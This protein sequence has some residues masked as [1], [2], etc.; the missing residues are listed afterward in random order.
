MEECFEK[1]ECHGVYDCCHP[2][3]LTIKISKRVNL[4][5]VLFVRSWSVLVSFRGSL[6]Q[7]GNDDAS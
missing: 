1:I 4:H 2:L 7:V 3:I 6:T 5:M